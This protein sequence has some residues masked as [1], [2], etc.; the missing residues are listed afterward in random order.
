MQEHTGKTILVIDDTPEFVGFVKALLE[1]NGFNVMT[2]SNGVEGVEQLKK[3]IPDLVSLDLVMP[4]KSGIKFFRE[5]RTNREWS[6]I[7]VIIVTG[8]ARDSLGKTDFRKLFEGRTI[9]GPETYLE[10]PIEPEDY[11]RAIKRILKIG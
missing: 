9:S 7:P 11:I 8:H 4:E 10:K 1:D 3:Q 2:A 6:K 5:I